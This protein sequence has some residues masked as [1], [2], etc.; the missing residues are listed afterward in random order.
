MTYG[1]W[2]CLLLEYFLI[3]LHSLAFTYKNHIDGTEKEIVAL[4]PLFGMSMADKLTWEG[5]LP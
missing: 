1:P 3:L 5:T 2:K 4:L